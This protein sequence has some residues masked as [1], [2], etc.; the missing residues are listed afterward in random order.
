ML[1][2]AWQR[3]RLIM[4]LCLNGAHQIPPSNAN[5]LQ[6]HGCHSSRN[7]NKVGSTS[8][9]YLQTLKRVEICIKT[10]PDIIFGPFLFFL[11]SHPCPGTLLPPLRPPPPATTRLRLCSH[12]RSPLIPFSSLFLL[13]LFLSSAMSFLILIFFH[14]FQF[15]FISFIPFFSSCSFTC[16]CSWSSY[17]D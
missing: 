16:V 1:D 14:V 9:L 13:F 17:Y 15:Y 7:T 12:L 5:C 2:F 4:P 10:Y 11:S 3:L 6:T 8:V